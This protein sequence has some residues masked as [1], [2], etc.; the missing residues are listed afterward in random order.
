MGLLK[1]IARLF[2]APAAGG[3]RPV[4]PLYVAC[5]R[6]GEVIVAEINLH[7][8]LSLDDDETG[9]AGTNYIC[10]KVLTGRQRCFQPIE[11]VLRFDTQRRLVECQVTGGR[12]VEAP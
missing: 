10:R 9:E 4:L 7:N 2:A 12:Q 3:A 1:K 11:V 8:D 5:A 6:C